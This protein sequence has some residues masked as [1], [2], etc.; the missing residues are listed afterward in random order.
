MFLCCCAGHGCGHFFISVLAVRDSIMW[1][2]VIQCYII[3]TN[4][5]I[6]LS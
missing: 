6:S 4:A 3:H 1:A 2:F 5:N